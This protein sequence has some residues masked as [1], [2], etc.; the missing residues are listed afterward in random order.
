MVH[1]GAMR[2]LL[3]FLGLLG[4]CTGSLKGD[5]K[6]VWD[7]YGG[8][9]YSVPGDVAKL[10]SILVSTDF[11]NYTSVPYDITWFDSKTG[12]EINNQTGRILVQ[13][14]TLWFLRV[15]L[16]DNGTYM[17][18]LR[19]PSECFRQNISLVVDQP[20]ASGCGKP[21]KIKKTITAGQNAIL[22]CPLMDHIKKLKSY[23]IVPDSKWYK[24]C[25][26]IKPS[27]EKYAFP[28]TNRLLIKKVNPEDRGVYTCTLTFTLAGVNGS[29]SESIN[30]TV[31]VF[32][33]VVPEIREPFNEIIKA[34]TGSNFSKRC[35]VFV[36][37]AG[38]KPSFG[39]KWCV[40]GQCVSNDPSERIYAEKKRYWIQDHPH[41]GFFF[42]RKLV[43]TVLREEDFYQNYTC[44]EDSKM[45]SRYFTLLPPDPNSM[46]PIGL[47]FAGITVLF[48]STVFVYR[49][50]KIDIVLWFRRVFPHL[51]PNKDLD[52]KLYDAYVAYPQPCDSGFSEEMEKFALHTLPEV[53]EEDCGYQL[54][55]AGRDCLPGQAI[56]DS[57]EENLQASRRVLLL[58]T[59]S[60][61]ISKRHASSTT[62]IDNKTT[63][64]SSDCSKNTEKKNTDENRNM[65]SDCD[66]Q[67]PKFEYAAALH[68]DLLEGSLRVVLVELEEISP[69]QLA[70]FPES[71]RQLRKK[72][73]AAC[74]WKNQRKRR[75]SH[76]CL[77]RG[78]DEETGGQDTELSPSL[79]SS[80]RFW[81]EVRYHMPVTGKRR[82]TPNNR[83]FEKK[84]IMP[85]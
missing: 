19:T 67:Q 63:S 75:S 58:Y 60:T 27:V 36:P 62:S 23:N 46:L 39:V 25:D 77:R 35:L 4:A 73:G 28:N 33:P 66:N 32:Y 26:L 85:D 31:R 16:G 34:P 68:K 47:V 52:G 84:E 21:N 51:Y 6:P 3:V 70:L 18:I 7:E 11:F 8:T 71:V 69:A 48:I 5:C 29:V 10:A 80:S 65:N 53:L 20:V 9:V 43:F 41:K 59:A 22:S 61:F 2:G 74:W 24:G 12:Q 44:I 50:F 78:G 49:F 83:P 40:R 14:E 54:F 17:I 15:T 72:Q 79:S 42:E 38:K 1:H 76:T 30:A 82:C 13:G 57:V 55:I 45:N 64:G 56:V 37:G 81:K